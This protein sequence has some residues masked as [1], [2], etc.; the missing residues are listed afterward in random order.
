VYGWLYVPRGRVT[1]ALVMEVVGILSLLEGE[2]GRSSY[3]LFCRRL[4]Y[5]A[6]FLT[7]LLE[8]AAAE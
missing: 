1:E 3:G 8:A 4:V 2:A 6:E 7:R 5:A